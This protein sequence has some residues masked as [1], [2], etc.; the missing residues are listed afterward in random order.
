MEASEAMEI[1]KEVARVGGEA[2]DA[3]RAKCR[4]EAMSRPAVILEWGDPREWRRE[5]GE[6]A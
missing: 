3:L 4:W 6:D 5:D 1:S 2:E